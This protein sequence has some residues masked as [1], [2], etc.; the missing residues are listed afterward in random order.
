MNKNIALRD[1]VET[2]CQLISS[3]FTSQGW[4]KSVE[5]YTGYFREQNESHREVIIAEYRGEFAGYVTIVWKTKYD[6]FREKGIPEIKDLNV[7]IKYRRQGIATKL[8][9]EAEK[10]IS[11]RS[12]HAGLGVGLY[13]DYGN[14]Q[15]MY[16]KRGYMPDG[17]GVCYRDKELEPGQNVVLDDDLN[18]MMIK[19]LS[20]L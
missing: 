13:K 8:M 17:R 19:K 15:I 1:M 16:A 14:A 10:R 4:N 3:A 11:K 20:L 9:D 5:I 12:K 7:L 2:D 18:L 6:F